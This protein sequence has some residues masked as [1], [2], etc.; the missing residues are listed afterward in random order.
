MTDAMT[1]ATPLPNFFVIGAAKCGTT[2]LHD[3]LS[4]HPDVFAT[5]EKETHFLDYGK[6]YARGVSYWLQE[7]YEGSAEFFARGES[8]PSYLH[9]G[10]KVIPRIQQLYENTDTPRLICMLRDPV[11]RAYSHYLDMVRSTL[12]EESFERALELE[13]ERIA[14][15]GPMRW[16]RYFGDG[17]YAAQLAPWIDAFG[18]ESLLL[19]LTEDLRARPRETLKQIFVF[20]GLRDDVEIDVTHRANV[21]AEYTSQTAAR[22]VNRP[23]RIKTLVRRVL[24]AKQTRRIRNWL[25]NRFRRSIESHEKPPLPEG[26]VTA[27][28]QRYHDD[29]TELERLLDR[30]LSHWKQ[31]PR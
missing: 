24:P 26:I 18:R 11:E 15:G 31:P 3:L 30:D 4:L 1:D 16:R 17:L 19:L 25:E 13:P 9:R 14:A 5:A 7:H 8:T 22:L 21:A 23:T 12:E 2:A 28:R 20:L 27:L 10:D 29:I 6:R